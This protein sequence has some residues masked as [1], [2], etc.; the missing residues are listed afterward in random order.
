MGGVRCCLGSVGCA[1]LCFRVVFFGCWVVF[2]FVLGY[3]SLFCVY[4][5]LLDVL[6]FTGFLLLFFLLGCISLFFA[7]ILVVVL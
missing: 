4:G 3:S 2:H 5:C 1:R 7:F 6:Y